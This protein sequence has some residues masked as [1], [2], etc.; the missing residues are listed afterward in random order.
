MMVA[1][2]ETPHPGLQEFATVT[3]LSKMPKKTAASYGLATGRRSVMHELTVM[4][5]PARS[6]PV[7]ASAIAT[8][9]ALANCSQTTGNVKIGVETAF[10]HM[11]LK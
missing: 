11:G 4:G 5:K 7:S 1:R 2:E 6:C 10:S 3:K 8:Q 9:S